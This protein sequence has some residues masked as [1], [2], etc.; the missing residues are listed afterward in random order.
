VPLFP[1]GAALALL[2]QPLHPRHLLMLHIETTPE[3]EAYRAPLAASAQKD[4]SH[5]STPTAAPASPW[6]PPF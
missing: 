4:A 3:A 6:V 5:P 2:L 1:A